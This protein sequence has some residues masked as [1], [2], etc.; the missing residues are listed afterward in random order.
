[1]RKKMRILLRNFA[2]QAIFKR[3]FMRFQAFKKI[4]EHSQEQTNAQSRFTL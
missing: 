4:T 1:M 2:R 3:N